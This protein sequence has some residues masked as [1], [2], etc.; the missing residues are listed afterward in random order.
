MKSFLPVGFILSPMRTGFS[1]NETAVVYDETTVISLS[2]IGA[3]VMLV[4][5]SMVFLI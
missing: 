4:V 2:F 3:G 1:P 5:N